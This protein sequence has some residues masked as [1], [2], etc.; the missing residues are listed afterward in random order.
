MRIYIYKNKIFLIIIVLLFL[1][2]STCNMQDSYKRFYIE[3]L[4]DCS[5][6]EYFDLEE[7][8]FARI[9]EII[10]VPEI[11]EIRHG[12]YIIY[13]SAYSESGLENITIKNVSLK[14]DLGIFFEQEVDKQIP[15]ENQ[16]ENMY[17]GWIDV[18]TFHKEKTELL[19]GRKIY[20]II[21]AQVDLQN[22]SIKE[23][24][25]YEITIKG[26][27]SLVLPV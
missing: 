17:E 23:E 19:N 4:S 3:K 24:K 7:L 26:Y 6:E 20:L 9:G 11:K 16:L 12:E 15:F 2:I 5:L 25:I 8:K 18:G 1:G 13:L 27:K 10:I 14:D 21:Q 22:Q